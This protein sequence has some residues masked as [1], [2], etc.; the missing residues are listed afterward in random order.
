MGQLAARSEVID[1]AVVVTAEV[2]GVSDITI[3]GV[4]FRQPAALKRP[5]GGKRRGFEIDDA[6]L[7]ARAILQGGRSA[8]D[9]RIVYRVRVDEDAMV[10]APLEVFLW[11]PVGQNQDAVKS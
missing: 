3:I 9:F 4:V 1:E 2:Q 6:G 7:C 5:F 8:D 10:V 11:K